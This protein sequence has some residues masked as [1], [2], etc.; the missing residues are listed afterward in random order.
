MR[1]IASLVILLCCTS[2]LVGQSMWQD[3]SVVV[4]PTESETITAYHSAALN[5]DVLEK[6]LKAAPMEFS[7][8]AKR[9][10]ISIAFPMP[11]GVLRNFQVVESPVMKAGISAR[12]P[13]I[14]SYSGVAEDDSNVRMRFSLSPDG[15]KVILRSE[16]GL[17]RIEPIENAPQ[18]YSSYFYK[19]VVDKESAARPALSCGYVPSKEDEI[20][21]HLSELDFDI[22]A[23]EE[24]SGAD[25]VVLRTYDMAISTTIAF[26][27]NAGGTVAGVLSTL[28]DVVNILNSIFEREVA[29]RFMLIDE[30]DQLIFTTLAS[31]PYQNR[32]LGRELINQSQEIFNM[33]IP[34]ANYGI[35]H[36]IT[37]GCSD[38][39]G[40]ASLG[41][42][43][44]E[45]RA[46]GISCRPNG[47]SIMRMVVRNMAHEVGHQFFATHTMS[48]CGDDENNQVGET[49][50]E[51]GSGSTIMSYAGGCGSD[52]IQSDSDDYYHALN[53]DQI[54]G[55]S[56]FGNGST[57]ATATSTGNN[58]PEITLD[59]EDNFYIPTKTPFMLEATATDSDGD[60]LLYCW[61]QFNPGKVNTGSSF[62]DAANIRSF[63]PT[64]S[65]FR[66]IP[67]KPILLNGNSESTEVLP[68]FERDYTFRCTVRD[69][70]PAG[71]GTVWEELNFKVA[72]NAGPFLVS[73]PSASSDGLMAGQQV[74]VT[75]DVANTTNAKV[76]CQ[77]VNILLSTDGG[78][79]FNI[80]LLENVSNDGAEFVTIPDVTTT[81][82]RI[83]VEAANNIFFN[84]SRENFPIEAAAA[85]SFALRP[86]PF[87]QEVCLPTNASVAIQ[88]EQI[89]GFEGEI[90]LSLADLPEG[91]TGTFEPA[92]VQA[93][94]STMLT[95]D[96]NATDFDGLTQINIVGTSADGSTMLSQ[97]VEFNIVSNNFSALSL[98]SPESGSGGL[99]GNTTF[100]WTPISNAS[101]Y[102]FQLASSPDFN[103]GTILAEGTNLT[104]TSFMPEDIFLDDSNTFYWRVRPINECGAGAYTVPSVF[105][106]AN[107][108]CLPFEQTEPVNIAKASGTIVE[109]IIEIGSSGQITDLNI[110]LVNIS[111]SPIGFLEVTLI[112]PSDTRAILVSRKCGGRNLLSFG[113]DDEAPSSVDDCAAGLLYIPHEP[114]AIFDGENIQGEWKLEVKV[115]N[116]GNDLGTINS[117]ELESCGDV[118]TNAPFLITNEVF[119][120]PPSSRSQIWT[121]TLEADDEDN[122]SNEIIYELLSAPQHGTLYLSE[123]ALAMGDSFTQQD[124]DGYRISYQ[125]NGD[126]ATEDG[127][128]FIIRDTDQGLF[129]PARFN[130]VIDD[131]ATVGTNDPAFANQVRIYPNPANTQVNIA[132]SE[133]LEQS[134]QVRIVNINGQEVATTISKRNKVL[135]FNTAQFADGIYFIQVYTDKAF[136]TER[137]VIQK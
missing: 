105:Q 75:W 39:G 136:Y 77:R 83:K 82:G 22:P 84:I 55:F 30:T 115:V 1:F 3:V 49:T 64:S 46:R 110:P 113:F 134:V 62:I 72:G 29:I 45:I 76:N 102:D 15:L 73:Y 13:N 8:A 98:T 129:G 85:P 28:N 59:Y 127:F 16:H 68:T 12:Y 128:D 35:G 79:N 9:N 89:A 66:M 126:A 91:V 96:M 6:K 100:E 109:S 17:V 116:S 95:L 132:L 25:P 7:V 61:E 103:A 58:E 10:P 131:E 60:A 63:P 34:N 71:G 90:Q 101:N 51:P 124:I 74:E 106:T 70:N 52:N 118:Q 94:A 104:A 14:K 43:C 18:A 33:R 4:E 114:L 119:A 24:K 11:D 57:C 125:H 21:Q 44:S 41:S 67:R 122:A 36:V 107:V 5:I 40:I 92:T 37:G 54:I 50:Y 69:N 133:N 121:T 53:L 120:L 86:M 19:D 123:E 32:N 112:S 135:A 48:S 99:V 87:Y 31:D 117:W 130:I 81:I 2:L 26:S 56:R 47:M 20:L 108:Q 80:P 65:S 38:V 88:T 23:G 27:G 93:G 137:V 97:A 78:N 111:F 42:V